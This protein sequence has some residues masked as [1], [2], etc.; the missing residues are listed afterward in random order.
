MIG[1]LVSALEPDVEP[2]Q[3]RS[4]TGE[5]DAL[6]HDVGGELG[7]RLVERALYGVDDRRHRLFDRRADVTGAR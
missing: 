4:A 3:Q 2:V 5:D 7:W 1:M 6:G